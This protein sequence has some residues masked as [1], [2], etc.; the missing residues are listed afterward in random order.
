M[1]TNYRTLIKTCTTRGRAW[2]RLPKILLRRFSVP[3]LPV[4]RLRRRLTNAILQLHNFRIAALRL[5]AR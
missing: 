3:L 5:W 2:K 4:R 1:E